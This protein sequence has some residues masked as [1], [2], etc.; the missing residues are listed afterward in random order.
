MIPFSGFAQED[1]ATVNSPD[2]N[3]AFSLFTY[4][5]P[6]SVFSQGELV[7]TVSCNGTQIIAPS[8]LNL[9][10]QGR[11]DPLGTSV[12]ITGTETVLNNRESYTLVTGRSSSVDDLYNQLRVEIT[13]NDSP[14]FRF[15]LHIRAFDDGVA[16][17]YQL[18]EQQAHRQVTLVDEKTEFRFVDDAMTY[19]LMLP[20]F[21]SMYEGEFHKLP[22][23]GLGNQGG[24]SAP[25]DILLGLPMLLELPG[26]AWVAL[27]DA[28][29]EGYA[30]TYLRPTGGWT[31]YR[32]E[33]SL[34]QQLE[35]PG[36]TIRGS[37]PLQ[38]SWKTIMI[39]DHPGRFAETDIVTSLNPP[40]R[41][42]DTSWIEAGKATWDWWSG[43]LNPEGERE[44]TTE[45]IKR[46]VDFAAESGFRY[47]LIDAGWSTDDLTQTIEGRVDVPAVVEYAAEKDVR[48]WVW[49][50]YAALIEQ[51][52]EAFKTFEEWGVAGVKIDFVERDDPEG[53]AFYYESAEKAAE[54]H[55]ML[56][57]HGSTK[58]T[59]IQRTW[60]NVMGY[61]AVVGMEQSKAGRRDNATSHVMLPF[62]RMITGLMD[63]TPGGFDNV[64]R[65]AFQ[66]RMMNPMVMGTRAH[67]LAMY[68][69]YESP[70]QMV[71]DHPSAYRGEPSFE[72]I[73][74]VPAT[75]D[76]SRVIAGEPGEFITMARRSGEKWFVGGMT[77]E[78]ARAV[79]VPLTFLG[80]GSYTATIYRDAADSGQHPKHILIEQQ[81]VDAETV[82]D[83][84]MASAGG[85][86][87]QITP[88]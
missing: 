13:D 79:S 21:E 34:S 69:I 45:N 51:M 14:E 26:K 22:I 84:S 70:F 88:E 71:S 29:L 15:E 46:Y 77:N 54:H 56:D 24:V 28:D 59:G 64:T 76:Q 62:T 87:V 47:M 1:R 65:E 8:A 27:I 36:V 9:E 6:D 82:L 11:E 61:E 52:E 49:A 75:W 38:T 16:F 83:F 42:D 30:A 18:P 33:T 81:T 19:A 74:A 80:K 37:L 66:P 53:I 44:F 32:F 20:H 7:Y 35:N 25:Q 85:F 86:S 10:L 43:S 39:A 50:Y 63:Y 12:R 67:H 55:L 48:I 72:F 78:D 57:Y 23:T 58:P 2:G 60:P 68:V 40:S 3:I 4:S 41:I 17:R 5:S 73:K 31:G